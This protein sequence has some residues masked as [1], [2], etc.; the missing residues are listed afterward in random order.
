MTKRFRKKFTIT[1]T[2]LK[3]I[4]EDISKWKVILCSQTRKFTIF[5]MSVLPKVTYLQ[6]QCNLCQVPRAFFV[7]IEKPRSQKDGD[8]EDHEFTPP[9][10]TSRQQLHT[11]QF[12][13]ELKTGRVAPTQVKI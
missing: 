4:K 6:T 7:N 8:S 9:R 13:L 10:D 3:E 12:T 2:L 11:I 5:K 1:N